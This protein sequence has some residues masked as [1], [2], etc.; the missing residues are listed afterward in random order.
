MSPARLSV[1]PGFFFI[2]KANWGSL[3]RKLYFPLLLH[4][5][6]YNCSDFLPKTQSF[7]FFLPAIFHEEST[8]KKGGYDNVCPASEIA[9]GENTGRVFFEG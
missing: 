1:G 5:N 4:P 2:L 7:I 8:S 3:K 6:I 9:Q